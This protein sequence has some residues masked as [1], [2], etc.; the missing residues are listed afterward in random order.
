M[1][2][3]IQSGLQDG[4]LLD[5]KPVDQKQKEEAA[6]EIGEAIKHSSPVGNLSDLSPEPKTPEPLRQPEPPA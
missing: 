1:R 6:L 3:K 5:I 4:D 2:E